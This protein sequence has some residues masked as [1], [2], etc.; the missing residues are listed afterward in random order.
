MLAA[1]GERNGGARAAELR[2]TLGVGDDSFRRT[3]AAL[4]ER[5]WAA[6]NPGYGH[7]LRPEYIL[8]PRGHDLAEPAA[9]LAALLSR[10]TWGDQ[11]LRKWPLPVVH[12][13]LEG[14]RRFSEIE[15]HLAGPPPR[16]LATALRRVDDLGL[17]ARRVESGASPPHAVYLPTPRARPLATPLGRLSEVLR[18]AA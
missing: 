8:T 11:A 9:D 1:M 15:D 5:G 4:I 3:I 17:V 7:P 13:T 14:R 12:S 6:P 18:G 2:H 10:R 16:A